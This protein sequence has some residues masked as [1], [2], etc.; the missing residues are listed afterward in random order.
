MS[1]GSERLTKEHVGDGVGYQCQL[2]HVRRIEGS[3]YQDRWI[4]DTPTPEGQQG[5]RYRQIEE[6]RGLPLEDWPTT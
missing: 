3:E 1:D 2:R 5:H 6:Y 4:S